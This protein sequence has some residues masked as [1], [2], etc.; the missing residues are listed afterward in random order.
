MRTEHEE[1]LTLLQC[2]LSIR[3]L[4]LDGCTLEMQTF[5]LAKGNNPADLATGDRQNLWFQFG[6]WNSTQREQEFMGRNEI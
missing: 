4:G 5:A 1:E 6:L 2:S 3:K